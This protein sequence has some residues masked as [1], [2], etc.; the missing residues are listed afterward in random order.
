MPRPAEAFL[1]IE[2]SRDLEI[3]LIGIYSRSLGIKQLVGSE[4]T[5]RRLK[6]LLPEGGRLFTFNGHCF[7]L[8]RIQDQLGMRLR[9][10]MDSHDLRYEC[11]DWGLRGGQK[12]IERKVGY[13]RLANP[14]GYFEVWRLWDQCSQRPNSYA[15]ERLLT[16][17]RFDIAGM[18][19]IK[20]YLEHR[21]AAC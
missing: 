20:C 16:Y 14:L 18:R 4:C 7:D 19:A 6:R 17:N 3:I 11:R 5:G 9:E 1:D 21:H 12:K 2:T 10:S 13:R 15:R 8:P